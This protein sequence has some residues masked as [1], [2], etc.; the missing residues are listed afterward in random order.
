MCGPEVY[1]ACLQLAVYYHT[2]FG[3]YPSAKDALKY[4]NLSLAGDDTGRASTGV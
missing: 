2:G 1:H 3:V 4:L